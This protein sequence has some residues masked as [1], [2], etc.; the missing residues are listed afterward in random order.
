MN[1]K[2]KDHLT[3]MRIYLKNNKMKMKG[4]KMKWKVWEEMWLKPMRM[5]L[6]N[7]VQE[8]ET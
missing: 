8:N 6:E 1:L 2:I 7:G 4:P 5:F 3:R